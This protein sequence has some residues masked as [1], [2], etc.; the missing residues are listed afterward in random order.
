MT[1]IKHVLPREIPLAAAREKSCRRLIVKTGNSSLGPL[2]LY[3]RCGFRLTSVKQ[4]H[5]LE[6]YAEPLYENGIRCVDQI[7]LEYS[8]PGKEEIEAALKEY[9]FRFLRRNREYEGRSYSVWS[10]GLGDRMANDL[11]G[12]VK[13]GRK[14]GTASARELYEEGESLP[15]AGELYLITYGNGM[16]A[17]IIETKE[18]R[19]KPF[20]GIGAEEAAIEGEGDGSLEYWQEA[21]RY[22]FAREYEEAGKGFSEDIPVIFEV[23]EVIYDEDRMKSKKGEKPH[24]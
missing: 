2:A 13:I 21:H 3:Q 4:N 11:A 20:S 8:L 5:F 14:R 22:F 6:N 1:V 24:V 7:L 10:F 23:F 17:C 15:A 19:E 18:I 9:W 16:P 12:L